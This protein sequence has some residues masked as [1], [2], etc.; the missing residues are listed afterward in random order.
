M[1]PNASFDWVELV[2]RFG[3]SAALVFF[4]CF[5]L[6]KVGKFFGPII[7]DYIDRRIAAD[8]KRAEAATVNAHA[9]SAN[10][11]T[12]AKTAEKSIDIQQENADTNKRFLTMMETLIIKIDHIAF[13]PPKDGP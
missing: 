7:R 13:P 11:E 12:L 5:C 4:G 10:A 9:A 2:E 6:W 3:V 8:E 1:P